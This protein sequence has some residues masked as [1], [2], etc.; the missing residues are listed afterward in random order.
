MYN[1][2]PFMLKVIAATKIELQRHGST[3]MHPAML[4]ATMLHEP[5]FVD[6]L[7]A[8]GINKEDMA[9]TLHDWIYY[10]ASQ[11]ASRFREIKNSEELN[12][13]LTKA[14]SLN[15]AYGN[16]PIGWVAFL[17]GCL[18]ITLSGQMMKECNLNEDHIREYLRDRQK[19]ANHAKASGSATGGKALQAY[20]VNL[21]EKARSGKIDR[22]IG[23]EDEVAKVVRTLCRRTKNNPL[24]VGD[25]GVGKTAIA[26][27]LARRIVEGDVPAVLKGVPVFAL[28]MGALLAGTR[29]RGDFEE[30]LKNVIK[31]IETITP[32]PIL[33]IDEI[34][35][36]V[37]AGSTSGGAMDASNLLKPALAS[38]SLRTMGAT[39]YAEY[40][41]Y[42]E[43]DKALVRRFQK[44]DVAE[45]S[46]P[47]AI[48]IVSKAAAG[49]AAHH[50]VRFTREAIEAAVHGAK[51][52]LS[53]RQLP[54]SAFD[55]IDEA[56]AAFT[57]R[58]LQGKVVNKAAIE[59]TLCNLAG[60]PQKQASKDDTAVLKDLGAKLN[61]AV[62]QQEAAIEALTSAIKLSRAGLRDP[63]K[64]IGN[65]LFAGPTGVGKTEVSK[66]LAAELGIELLRFDMSEYMEKHTVS[67]LIGAPPGY[68]GFD[69]GGLLTDAVDKNK[70]CVLL[71]DEIEKAHP[72]LYNILL[73]V[74]DH[75][76][77]TDHN[78][79][80]I[81]FTNV[82]LIMTTNAGASELT[83]ESM[84]FFKQKSTADTEAINRLF[85]PEFRNRL[86]AVV[87][88][89]HLTP[90]AIA[91]V[92]D[93]FIGQLKDRL[94]ARKVD[95][96]V[97]DPAMSFLVEHG[98][99]A[100]MGARPM[101]RL[102]QKEIAE[103]LSDEILFGRLKKGGHATVSFQ[104]AHDG[105]QPSLCLVFND[106]AAA[107][108]KPQPK[109]KQSPSLDLSEPA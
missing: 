83:K 95:I 4:L 47:D 57:V 9:D 98:Y 103:R 73:Q 76:T 17:R 6:F 28:D 81:D 88:F 15:S 50:K 31:E 23:R 68:V 51:R 93:K 32:K 102:I 3:I 39:T 29:Y 38:G 89:G 99:D 82:I 5:E 100:V 80:K 96:T 60:I 104:A 13:V 25:P 46:V 34:H 91:K 85:A 58:G 1:F 86:D 101:A 92:A 8:S 105:K 63:N 72:D 52:H 18:G 109:P 19:A 69:Q 43:K 37:G 42:F 67:R 10:A 61:K 59:R 16:P 33:F 94:A 26:E 22:L 107:K 75:G 53:G 14:A 77:L 84:G 97:D 71:L 20:C 65:Y 35:T 87:K 106:Q 74:M 49:Y 90:E 21:N 40:R 24:L 48:K 55:V 108:V 64:P 11:P 36:M 2:D 27:G 54:D 78:G 12:R 41:Q 66:Q 7:D 30:R 56:G 62:V 44:V 70:H 45:P 79:K